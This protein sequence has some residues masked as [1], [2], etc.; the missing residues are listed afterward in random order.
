MKQKLL[1]IK[2]LLVA[3]LLLGGANFA[4][5]ETVGQNDNSSTD[6][7]ESS[8]PVTLTNGNSHHYV[9]TQTKNT[10]ANNNGWHLCINNGTSDIIVLRPDNWEG[11]ANNNTGCFSNFDWETYNTEMNGAT[12]DMT[13]S[14][15]KSFLIMKSSIKGSDGT[16]RYYNYTKKLDNA[17]ASLNIRL[18]VHLAYLNITTSEAVEGWG[19]KNVFLGT[20]NGDGTVSAEDFESSNSLPAAWSNGGYNTVSVGNV[21]NVALP[22]VGSSVG[23]TVPTYVSGKT[24]Q[25]YQRQGSGTGLI[26]ASYTLG[27]TV[28]KGLLV[29]SGD[30]F[31][32]D[33][34]TNA[35]YFRF[36]DEEGNPV[37]TLNNNAT[38]NGT[39]DFQYSIGTGDAVNTGASALW[40]T[41]N[42][43]RII[44]LVMN[45]ET[46]DVV[47]TLDYI[48]RISSDNK[49]NQKTIS[50]NIGTGK[51]VKS[52]QVGR[53]CVSST[54]ITT[55]M[56][57]ISL[58]T[59]EPKFG[60]T[61]NYTN[62]GSPLTSD[63]GVAFEG[64]TINAAAEKTISTTTYVP[65]SGET[66]SFTATTNTFSNEWT[67][68]MVGSA[69]YTINY[70][71]GGAT[72]ETENGNAEV[73]TQVDATYPISLWKNT[74]KYYVADNED[75][76]FN[77]TNGSNVF[78]IELRLAA[79]DAVATI[80]A[81]YNSTTVGTFTSAEGVEGE[82]VTVYFKHVL[83]DSVN[84]KY[85]VTT[86]TDYG[87]ALTYGSSVDV[88]YS[89]DNDIVYYA[90][91]EDLS[92]A[93]NI[94]S[95]NYSGGSDATAPGNNA[96]SLTTLPAAYYSVE[97]YNSSDQSHVWRGL[98]IRSANSAST[99]CILVGIGSATENV[100]TGN[101]TVPQEMV[102]YLSGQNNNQ[103]KINQSC[104]I[105][106][107]IIR[108]T[109]E[110]PATENIV[111]S[112]A[113]MATYVSNYNLDFT[114]ATT[115]AYKVAVES[116]G[117][118][119]LTLVNEVPAKTP[120]LLV[121]AGGNG[122]GEN[123][124]ITTDAVDAVTGNDLVAGTGTAVATTDGDYTNMIL[125]NV[126]GNVGF[127]LANDQTVATNRAYLHFDSSL[128]PDAL[129]PMMM[130]FDNEVT[131][132]NEVKGE[133][134]KVNGYYDLQGRKVAQP[135]KGLYIVNGKKIII[136]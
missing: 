24:M 55:H 118:A 11:I 115:K 62:G 89:L 56:D 122:E 116:K 82:D 112:N 91:V 22:S 134:L 117:V 84:D 51:N 102:V 3:V 120:I 2:S 5:A 34:K 69:P 29:F 8:T 126:G 33:Y 72:I 46:G 54:N 127:Y 83:Y 37:L 98:Y 12:I 28:N 100:M 132:I 135:T 61:I 68:D 10:S 1:T 113:G 119:T 133:G 60:Y 110:L 20:D 124:A 7:A 18:A 39:T 121:C 97:G 23:E 32:S 57:N 64:A 58:Y 53:Y 67:V 4:W 136:K 27:S 94:N 35:I 130:V 48:G 75:T 92:G 107:I 49:R 6:L 87:K 47:F 123:I 15:F 86:S 95:G 129:A 74:V 17:P 93:T 73:G 9:F 108:K 65:A 63:T 105:D 104:S 26:Y 85:Y 44:D 66:T 21:D 99:S 131:G 71:Y 101:F 125:N 111:V 70:T 106:Y 19:V 52:I 40:R 30:F 59:V 109:G 103:G 25:R 76:S 42:S 90:E 88:D 81:V 38:S 79:T 41:Y 78:E 31:A 16:L 77:I 50:C 96:I 13:V 45:F 128:A 14:L 80:N 36:V 43:F 114:S